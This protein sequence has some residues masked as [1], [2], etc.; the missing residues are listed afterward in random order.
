MSDIP[1]EGR[2]CA[3]CGLKETN[4]KRCCNETY[5]CNTTCQKGDRKKHKAI[6]TK[7]VTSN[8]KR[9]VGSDRRVEPSRSLA[10]DDDYDSFAEEESDLDLET[11]ECPPR[12]DC[13]VCMDMLPTDNRKIEYMACCGKLL[14]QACSLDYATN[15]I[16]RGVDADTFSR[17]V[18]CRQNR[19][20]RSEMVAL[21]EA[22]SEKRDGHAI[23]LL[24]LGYE[25]GQYDL[26][27]NYQK[28]VELYHQATKLGNANAAHTLGS[29]Y[30]K[31][32]IVSMDKKKA[33]RLLCRAAKGGS[34]GSLHQLGCM[35]FKEMQNGGEKSSDFL[36][37]LIVAAELGWKDSIDQLKLFHD[38][39]L[40]SRDEYECT[41]RKY[42]DAVKKE[43]TPSR[44]KTVA[45]INEERAEMNQRP[46]G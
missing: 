9:I 30:M 14:C 44:D 38:Y 17:C 5:Y 16:E 12:N 31:G 34:V 18:F 2:V 7:A 46:I 13:P 8:K 37:Y 35:K 33:K 40:V 39:G 41:L 45:R 25:Y 26:P 22:A 19:P 28:A 11:Y 21:L 1:K 29:S 43:Q 3:H 36:S 20:N 10:V 24:A 27:I 15:S 4:L 42:L 32:D 23:Y 6:C